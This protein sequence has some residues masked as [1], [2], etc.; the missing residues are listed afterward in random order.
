MNNLTDINEG[1][2][3]NL[4]VHGVFGIILSI[5]FFFLS[6]LLGILLIALCI[7]LF[8]TT[9]GILIDPGKMQYKKYNSWLGFKVG[10]WQ[11]LSD[12]NSAKLILSV[13]T[14]K[15]INIITLPRA[16]EAAKS[17]TFDIVITDSLSNTTLLY[18]FLTYKNARKALEC[19]SSISGVAIEDK[20]RD[21]IAANQAKRRN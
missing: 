1:Y 18:D 12:L 19:L 9:N 17:R 21:K 14:V 10:K 7:S 16:K 8:T 2:T 15:L 13:E 4:L 5:P 6:I 11:H 20:V 3:N